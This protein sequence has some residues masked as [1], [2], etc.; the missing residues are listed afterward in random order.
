MIDDPTA[1]SGPIA[2]AMAEKPAHVPIAL[3]RSSLS[4]D[5]P[6]NANEQGIRS[7]AP[8]PW[9]ARARINW[10]MV[11]ENPHHRDAAANILMPTIKILR[12][13]N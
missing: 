4:N 6:I 1:S 2:D 11:G 7:A 5:A 10:E 3:P 9:I 13:P 12:R 8:N